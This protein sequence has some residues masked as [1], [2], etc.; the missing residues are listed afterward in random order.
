MTGG[1]GTNPGDDQRQGSAATEPQP[2]PQR[3]GVDLHTPDQDLQR[4]T[5]QRGQCLP[6]PTFIER[7]LLEHLEAADRCRQP[8][9]G[10]V[11]D[12]GI[13]L[14]Q[15]VP[16]AVVAY[17]AGPDDGAVRVDDPSSGSP[18]RAVAEL[19]IGDLL[20]AIKDARSAANTVFGQPGRPQTRFPDRTL[21]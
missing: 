10:Q 20:T 1:S 3:V 8:I 13:E 15:P 14:P 9:A 7:L 19:G 17:Q 6:E 16:C 4:S 11:G 18:H 2:T 21:I 12:V 5:V